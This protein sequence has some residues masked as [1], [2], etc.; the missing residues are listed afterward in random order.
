MNKEDKE[1]ID[2]Y[3][4]EEAYAFL[5]AELK[6]LGIE[7]PDYQNREKGKIMTFD[8]LMNSKPNHKQ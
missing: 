3:T 5:Q 6:N 1:I 7:C 2:S 4:P 8:D